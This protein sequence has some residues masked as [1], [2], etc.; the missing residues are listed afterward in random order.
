MLTD[1][2]VSRSLKEVWNKRQVISR[3][4]P[5]L[6]GLTFSYLD[7][8]DICWF[9]LSWIR[10]K[11]QNPPRYTPLLLENLTATV[12]ILKFHLRDLGDAQR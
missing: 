7:F 11:Y 5:C 6:A 4:E 3:R 9:E 8:V 10:L 2:E 1:A 12:V